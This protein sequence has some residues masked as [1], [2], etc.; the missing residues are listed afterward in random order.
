[1]VRSLASAMES[2][3]GTEGDE[4]LHPKSRLPHGA[5]GLTSVSS[6]SGS[7]PQTPI[8]PFWP[9]GS[10]MTSDGSCAPQNRH[11]WNQELLRYAVAAADGLTSNDNVTGTLS[12]DGSSRRYCSDPLKMLGAKDCDSEDCFDSGL[13][14]SQAQVGSLKLELPL[15]E[16]DYLMPSPQQNQQGTAYID[17]IGDSKHADGA[18]SSGYATYPVFLPHGQTNID[19]PEYIMSQE[20]IPTQTIGIPVGGM[21]ETTSPEAS[22]VPQTA[23]GQ[24]YQPQR[25]SE[26]E[27]DHEYYN[28]F[29]RLQRELQPLR[30]SETTV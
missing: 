12:S 22:P 18:S 3:E 20:P 17:L 29:D 19:N 9:A 15:D 14:K 11:N 8:K 24:T 23:T 4:Y 25:S 30:K 2:T 21:M 16:D 5:S 7:P 1:M 26:E 10:S 6:A 28:D 13:S 27:S